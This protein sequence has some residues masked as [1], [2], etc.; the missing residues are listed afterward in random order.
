MM[1][2]KKKKNNN[3]NNKTYTYIRTYLEPIF[4]KHSINAGISPFCSIRHG[5]K[6]S[7]TKIHLIKFSQKK[8]QYKTKQNKE[9][10]FVKKKEALEKCT[11]VCKGK[12]NTHT[13][14]HTHTPN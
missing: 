2:K 1:M 11:N 12:K 4:E 3:N 5:G 10:R 7:W 6:S 13:Y 14:T 8:Q 9:R